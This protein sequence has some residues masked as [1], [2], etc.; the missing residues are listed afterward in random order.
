MKRMRIDDLRAF[1]LVAGHGSLQRAA[2]HMG[3]TQ[4]ALSKALARLE[5]EADVRFFDRTS[6]G[7]RLT[8]VGELLLEQARKVVLAN[9]DL[10]GVIDAQRAARVGKVRVA[11]TPQL[12][13]WFLTPVVT[14][15]L[16]RRPLATF[17]IDTRL[18]VGSLLALQAGEVDFACGGMTADA[19]DG[20]EHFP[21]RSLDLCVVARADHPRRN[22]WKTLVDMA[23]ERWALPQPSSSLYQALAH[24]LTSLDLPPPRVAVEWTGSG[25]PITELIRHSDLLGLLPRRVVGEPEGRGLAV[26]GALEAAEQPQVGLFWRAEGYLSPLCLEFREAV[27]AYSKQSDSTQC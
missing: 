11:A 25:V 9:N 22:T 7:V 17:A 14:Q 6:R 21:L 2:S 15:F 10:D 27:I 19:P 16:A 8:T 1:V 4:S 20:L 12:V 24:R 13:S 26:A 23:D 3:V 18:T 5:A